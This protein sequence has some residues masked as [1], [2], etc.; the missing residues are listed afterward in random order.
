VVAI[1]R[2][3][4]GRLQ[5]CLNSIPAH[6]QVVYVDSGSSDDSVQNALRRGAEIVQLDLS[7]P[8]TAARAR[9][10]GLRRL[11]EVCTQVKYVQFV[12]GDCE[13]EGEWIESAA[14]FLEA[15]PEVAAVCGRRRERFPSASFYNKMCDEEWDTPVGP[16]E[17]SGGDAMIRLSA[18]QEVGGYDSALMAGEEPELCARLRARGW[19][20]WR[21]PAPMTVHDAAMYRFGQWWKR[22]LRSGYGYAQVWQKTR[23]SPSSSLYKRELARA[24]VWTAGVSGLTLVA[25]FVIGLVGLALAP[26]VWGMEFVRLARKHGARKGAHLLIAKVAEFMGAVRFARDV[27]FKHRQ[28]GIF[29]K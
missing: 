25:V 4:G 20:I 24:V 19:T 5:Q 12:D 18:M 2:N 8:F 14:A 22:A 9:N 6:V 16:T 26:L 15:H 29:Y 13:I 23:R 1:G 27:L 3:E 28:R 7:R 10:E 17:A 21:L 11:R